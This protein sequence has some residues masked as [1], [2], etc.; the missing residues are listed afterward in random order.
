MGFLRKKADKCRES[1]REGIVEGRDIHV[2]V[3]Q[4]VKQAK[5]DPDIDY[6]EAAATGQVMGIYKLGLSD[7]CAI[8]SEMS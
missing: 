4:I 5:A 6:W 1:I 3:A 2:V 8:V 7:A